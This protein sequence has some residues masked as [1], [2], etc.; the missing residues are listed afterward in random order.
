MKA[1]VLERYGGPRGLKYKEVPSPV[2]KADEVLIKIHATT[3]TRGD[4]EMR[5][6]KFPIVLSLLIR[7]YMG[8]FKPRNIILGQELCGTI[9]EAGPEVKDYKVGDQVIATTGFK[10]GTYAEFI[11]LKPSSDMMTIGLKPESLSPNEAAALPVAGME[12][13]HYLSLGKIQKG[14]HILINGAAGSFGTFAVQLAKFYGA[15]VTAVDAQD[16]LDYLR[17]IG[18]DHCL[19]YT[20]QSFYEN[21]K[22]YDIIFDVVGKTLF[23]KTIDCLKEE[24][25]YIIAVP[26]FSHKIMRKF[27]NMGHK[28]VLL[29]LSK[30]SDS[31][32]KKVIDLVVEAPIKIVI[33]RV[34]TLEEIP[35][36]HDIIEGDIKKGN[37]VIGISEL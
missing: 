8:F 28:K 3:V 36:A 15:I 20:G 7:V 30:P 12:A 32:L 35:Q 17:S 1:V 19:D 11:C 29:D 31:D 33:D 23:S 9:I 24:G 5:G 22:T 2:P 18:A 16:K 10:F 26:R 6:L 27:K 37:L 25:R 14:D 13:L 21:I 4:A 34:M